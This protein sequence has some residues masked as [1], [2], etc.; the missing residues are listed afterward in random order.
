[1]TIEPVTDQD[2]A[3]RVLE[4][5]LPVLVDFWADNCGPCRLLAPVLEDVAHQHADDL[6]V[7]KMSVPDNPE[8]ASAYHV[9]SMPTMH[10]FKGGEVVKTI[11]GAMP[12][13]ALL[14]ELADHITTPVSSA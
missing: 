7:V 8:T 3:E 10:L 4:S 11:I 1:L 6:V 9:M 14:A 2:F 5:S 12:K 13:G